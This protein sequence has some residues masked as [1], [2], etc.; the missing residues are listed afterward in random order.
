MAFQL[1]SAGV[2]R[3][4]A[5]LNLPWLLHG[6]TTRRAGDFGNGT[7][8]SEALRRLGAGGMHLKTVRQIHSD[9]VCLVSEKDSGWDGSR[10]PEADALATALAGHVLGVR[11]ADC[12]PVLLVDRDKRA[13]AAVHAGWRGTHQ[14]IAA[15]GVGQM[16]A[17]FGS[18]PEDLEAAI[19]PGIAACCFEVG[20]DVAGQFDPSLVL[21]AP[22]GRPG[23]ASLEASRAN[24]RPRV[25]LVA[26]NRRQLLEQ[27][28]PGGN[29]WSSGYCTCCREDDFFSYRRGRDTARMLA[30][31][32]IQPTP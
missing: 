27:G 19:G 15:R 23:N 25:D 1:D 6:F 10:R 8:D 29:I 20:P 13:V 17:C 7:P 3:L 9:R 21:A 28:I 12:L 14:Q 5:W 24:P 30:F 31:I 4:E 11:T 16:R 2:L 22:P 26:A 18:E 32:G